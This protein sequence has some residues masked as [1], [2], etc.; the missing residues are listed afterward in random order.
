MLV[1]QV[2]NKWIGPSINNVRSTNNGNLID[3]ND[4]NLPSLRPLAIPSALAT[5]LDAEPR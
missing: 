5:L 2:Q 4:D 3:R 1:T